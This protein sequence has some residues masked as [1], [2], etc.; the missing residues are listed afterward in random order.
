MIPDDAVVTAREV[1]DSIKSQL[2]SATPGPWE[3]V[4]NDIEVPSP[5]YG[6][7]LETSVECGSYCYGG[8]VRQ[9]I[10]AG[11]REFIEN[12]ASHVARLTAALEAVLEL[13]D[14]TEQGRPQETDRPEDW[15]LDPEDVRDA[16][17]GAL[18]EGQ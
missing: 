8:S 15:M 12:A 9:A 4:G 14:R 3:F 10:S 1:L 11:D 7:I 17:E 6:M 16:I 18:K 5:G 2:A 13:C